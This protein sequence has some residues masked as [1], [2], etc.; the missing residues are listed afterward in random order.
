[1]DRTAWAKLTG[2]VVAN[3]FSSWLA[4]R[5]DAPLVTRCSVGVF[6]TLSWVF[7]VDQWKRRQRK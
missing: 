1:M 5:L 3:M 2:A 7:A 6:L 4:T